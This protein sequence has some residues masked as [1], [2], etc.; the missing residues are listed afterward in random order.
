[1]AKFENMELAEWLEDAAKFLLE[2]NPES[3]ALA[4]K[5]PD[6][7]TFTGYFKTEAE[8]LALLVGAIWA[9]LTLD[10]I[11]NN[12]RAVRDA[13]EETEEEDG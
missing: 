5:L 12:A 11:K 1:M 9:D 13:L 10:I 6:G 7:R 4:A 3:I 2:S 8:D